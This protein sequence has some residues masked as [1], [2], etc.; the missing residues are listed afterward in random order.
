MTGV[1][2]KDDF[3]RFDRED[4]AMRG[5]VEAVRGFTREEDAEIA[6]YAENTSYTSSAAARASAVDRILMMQASERAGVAEP[7]LRPRTQSADRPLRPGVRSSLR[8]R[9]IAAASGLV[10]AALAL[11]LW[12]RPAT[13]TI[14]IPAYSVIARGGVQEQRGGAPTGDAD[15]AQVVAPV[16]RVRGD[17]QL[18]VAVRPEIAVSGPVAARAFVVQGAEASEVLPHAEV[19][20]TGAIELRFRGADLIGTRRGSASLRV[21]VGR[22]EALRTL[23]EGA[24]PEPAGTPARWRLLTVPLEL[25]GP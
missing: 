15:G 23:A 19:A 18:V 20:P 5:L 21:I 16:Q 8:H 3:V 22:P 6:T 2:E 7:S 1:D 10:V 9:R 24:A 11:A 13:R 14:E 4:Q 12:M 25:T 17:S